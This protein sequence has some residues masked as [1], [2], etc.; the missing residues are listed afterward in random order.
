VELFASF[1]IPF[2]F[3]NAGLHLRPEQFSWRSLGLALVLLVVV[4]P[5]RVLPV[6]LQRRL[7]LKEAWSTGIR[8]GTAVVPTLVFT[9]VI[10]EILQE[11]F[12]LAP[13]LFGALIVFTLVNTMLPGFALGA[14]L[15][16][17]E[18][19]EFPTPSQI[20]PPMPAIGDAVDEPPKPG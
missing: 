12:L 6:A 8:I 20:P 19:P 5:L 2:Y 10:A 14:P 18:T 7:A 9:I 13:E 15:P 3:L 17:Y 4:L 16:E 11:R 1:F